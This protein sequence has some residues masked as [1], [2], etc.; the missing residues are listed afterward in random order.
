ME[1]IRANAAQT[2]SKMEHL[3]TIGGDNTVIDNGG[4]YAEP[5]SSQ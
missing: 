1:R 2:I 5:A 4:F 3:G